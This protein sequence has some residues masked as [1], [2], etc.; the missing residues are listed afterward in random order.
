MEL[1]IY[2]SQTSKL[3][4]TTK[5]PGVYAIL[6]PKSVLLGKLNRQGKL[7]TFITEFL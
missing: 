1:F 5:T 4:T 7:L 6:E 2:S 3:N